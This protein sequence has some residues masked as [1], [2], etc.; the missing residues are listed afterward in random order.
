MFRIIQIALCAVLIS[1]LG[2]PALAGG[3]PVCKPQPSMAANVTGTVYNTGAGL[4][5]RTEGLVSGCLRSTFSFF[6]PCLDLV[7]GCTTRVLA[8]IEKPFEYAEDW[9][10][11]R[12]GAKKQAAVKAH[13]T[14][15]PETPKCK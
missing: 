1:L 15:K 6:N 9:A 5:E 10:N 4:V 12:M 11:Q 13:Q 2:L 8:P 14:K 3:K 7:K